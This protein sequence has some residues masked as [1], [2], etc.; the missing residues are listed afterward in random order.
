MSGGNLIPPINYSYQLNALS[1]SYFYWIISLIPC[2]INPGEFSAMGQP[3][4][5]VNIGAKTVNLNRE[6]L[7]ISQWKY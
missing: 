1:K 6:N 4:I 3:R 2:K 5:K 7:L